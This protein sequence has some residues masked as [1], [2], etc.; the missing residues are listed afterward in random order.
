MG[1]FELWVNGCDDVGLKLYPLQDKD[2]VKL[3]KVFEEH[4]VGFNIYYDVSYSAWDK[5]EWIYAGNDYQTAYSIWE[6]RVK[7]K[8]SI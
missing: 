6:D 4:F 5:D 1:K 2:G 8:N 7:N 3:F